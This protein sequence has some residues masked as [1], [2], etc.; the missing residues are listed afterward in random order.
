M[1]DGICSQ[2]GK[3]NRA[4]ARFCANCGANLAGAIPPASPPPSPAAGAARRGREVVGQ[5]AQAAAPLAHQAAHQSWQASRQGMGWLARLTTG[6]GRAAFT[7]LVSP[8]PAVVGQVVSSPMEDWIPAPIE[9]GAITFVLCLLLSWLVFLLPVWWYEVLGIL[10]LAFLLLALN[11]A[12]VRR[13][14]FTRMMWG[15]LLRRAKQVPRLRFQV[16]DQATDQVV[17]LTVVGPR[18]GGQVAPGDDL[19]AYG[20]HYPGSNEVRAWKLDLGGAQSTGVMTAPRLIPLT[21]ALLLIPALLGLVWLVRFILSI[22]ST[23]PG[24]AGGV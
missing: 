22:L 18:T 7:E 8:Q 6:G 10:A 15:R 2:C 24:G 20:V 17:T 23:A 1:N 12:G 11:F 4:T 13:P 3:P 14:A 16:R 19:L 21:V 9:G 5:V